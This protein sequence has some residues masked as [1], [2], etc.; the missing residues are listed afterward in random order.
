MSGY[1]FWTAIYFVVS[2]GFWIEIFLLVSVTEFYPF[3]FPDTGTVVTCGKA[4]AAVKLFFWSDSL[5]ATLT[6]RAV[7]TVGLGEKPAGILIFS[8]YGCG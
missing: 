2:Y 8:E 3:S 4:L 7:R 5:T 6:L 1:V